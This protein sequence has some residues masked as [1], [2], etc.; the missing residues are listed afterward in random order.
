MCLR[1]PISGSVSTQAQPGKECRRLNNESTLRPPT[2]SQM[3]SW[4]V[5]PIWFINGAG[6]TSHGPALVVNEART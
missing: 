1:L 4:S 6:R 2:D 3:C 5:T